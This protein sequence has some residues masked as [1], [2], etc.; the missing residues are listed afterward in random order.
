MKQIYGIYKFD[1]AEQPTKTRDGFDYVLN[2]YHR[3]FKLH[4][5]FSE[6]ISH[7]WYLVLEDEVVIDCY[8]YIEERCLQPLVTT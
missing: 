3:L 2:G 4:T 7:S 6:S 8:G 5:P 1:S